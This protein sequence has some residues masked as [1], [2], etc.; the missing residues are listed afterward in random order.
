MLAKTF[1]RFKKETGV[2]F[3]IL[4][5]DKYGDCNTCVNAEL[6]SVFGIESK[7]IYARHWLKGMNK[8]KPFDQLE[9]LYIGHDLT[10]EQGKKFIEIFSVQYVVLPMEYDEDQTFTLVEKE[11]CA[12]GKTS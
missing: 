7:G 4:N 1:R 10:E 5:T 8:G 9:K 2:A 11:V 6:E 3:A 12:D